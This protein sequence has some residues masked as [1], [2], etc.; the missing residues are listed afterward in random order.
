MSDHEKSLAV[1]TSLSTP[2][3]RFGWLTDIRF[4][5]FV[6][7]AI[8]SALYLLSLIGVGLFALFFW[9]STLIDASAENEGTGALAILAI[10]TAPLIAFVALLLTLLIRLAFES[11]MVIFRIA[12]DLRHIRDK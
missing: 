5:S 1:S 9:T 8:V 7:P 10:W 4:N 12:E 11:I 6:T 2:G 3:R